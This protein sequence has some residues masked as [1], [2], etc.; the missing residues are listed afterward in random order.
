MY[1]EDWLF[2]VGKSWD[3]GGAAFVVQGEGSL[4]DIAS[5]GDKVRGGDV[6]VHLVKIVSGHGV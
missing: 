2:A 5:A 6:S 1:F 3:R 4:N